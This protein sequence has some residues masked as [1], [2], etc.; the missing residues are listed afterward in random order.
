MLC[1]SI[2]C[3]QSPSA[4][5]AQSLT[6]P[7]GG[8]QYRFSSYRNSQPLVRRNAVQLPERNGSITVYKKCRECSSAHPLSKKIQ[9]ATM[10]NLAV[11]NNLTLLNLPA[12][13]V[14]AAGFVPERNRYVNT[15]SSSP[16][17]KS[18]AEPIS[19]RPAR[20]TSLSFNPGMKNSCHNAHRF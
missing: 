20:A 17:P 1:G 4:S 5:V 9:S 10:E 11:S 19:P 18:Q 16:R 13:Q 7:I 8:N 6:I 15:P 2:G 14:L 12:G 3:C